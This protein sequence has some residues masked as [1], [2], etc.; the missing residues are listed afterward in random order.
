MLISVLLLTILPVV[1]AFAMRNNYQKEAKAKRIT[2]QIILK[3]I[4]GGCVGENT[5]TLLD[6]AEK[7]DPTNYALQ[8]YIVGK[9]WHT[10]RQYKYYSH[11]Q[12]I[13]MF[14]KIARSSCQTHDEE[15][16]QMA[17]VMECYF[18]SCSHDKTSGDKL[19]CYWEG[20][21]PIE[22]AVSMKYA[23][24]VSFLISMHEPL[25][26]SQ[27]ITACQKQDIKSLQLLL[28]AGCPT[29]NNNK[30]IED[31][32]LTHALKLKNDRCARMLTPFV[33]LSATFKSGSREV[34]I[35]EYFISNR[36]TYPD[37][38]YYLTGYQFT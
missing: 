31:Q 9:T 23:G 7:N 29:H 17:E 18:R 5:E 24:A 2:T 25:L 14:K 27:I 8:A 3:K 30:G 1:P 12:V 35:P 34:T 20:N 6:T 32:P 38:Y 37:A 26:P 16:Q 11:G 15:G 33:N 19:L 21:N 22:M 28:D 4:R 10:L 13:D 36:F